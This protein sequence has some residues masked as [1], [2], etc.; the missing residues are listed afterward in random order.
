MFDVI[1]IGCGIT[2]AS[3]AYELSKY[4]LKVGI[5]EA[6]NDVGDETSKAN[7]GIV[8]AGYDPTPHTLMAKLNVIGSE[9]Y[10][11]LC[12][13][14]NVHYEKIGSLVIGKKEDEGKILELYHRGLENGVKD[15]SIIYKDEIKELEPNINDD[16]EIALYAKNAAI[17]S[18]FEIT[19]AMTRNA[20]KNGVELFLNSK[21]LD[22]TKVDDYFLVKTYDNEFKT[23]YVINA[24]G[25]FADSIYK[26][27][28]KDKNNGFTIVPVKVDYF[29]LDKDEGKLI[30]HVIF[31]TP[32]KDGK[33]VLVS[34]TVH[35]N[36]IVGPD[37]KEIE[38]KEDFSVSQE[39]LDYVKDKASFTCNKINYRN[40]IRNFSGLRAKVLGF[41]DFIIGNS[42]ISGFINFAGIK[43][44][45][46]SAAPAF[47]DCAKEILKSLGQ[48]FILKDDYKI[49]PLPKFFKDLTKDEI[50]EKIKEDPL[51][52]RIICRCETVSEGEI[53]SWLHDCI[54]V[55]SVDGIKR[56]CNAGMGRCQGGFCQPK[57]L[58]IISR[59]LNI[60]PLEVLQDKNGSNIVLDYTKGGN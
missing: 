48:I 20:V 41:D 45:G 28:L 22:V 23:K 50:N 6:L 26:M 37:A 35:G 10:E 54:P 11:K 38:E 49:Y 55:L 57:I 7:S 21:V 52:G 47:G 24:A 4:E 16:I 1:I 39:S 51:Y 5:L 40:N 15:L 56:R 3:I 32:N 44:P 58:E 12:C 8:H 17:V 14:L 31:Q 27:V 9:M 25:V 29:L 19:L 2:G 59:E 43:S 33:G 18:P 46:L 36:L 13:D 42:V 53:V 34:K 60:K 30:N